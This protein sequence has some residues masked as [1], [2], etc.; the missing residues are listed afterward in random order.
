MV[1]LHINKKLRAKGGDFQLDIGLN[2]PQGSLTTIYGQS[3]A[4]KTSILRSIAGLLKPDQG[5]IIFNGEVWYSSEQRINLAPQ[6]RNVGYVFQDYA[7]FPNMT[8]LE[9][10]RF[11]QRNPGSGKTV[12]EL[13]QAMDLSGMEQRYPETLSGGQKQ[14]VALARALL[15]KPNILLLDEPLAALDTQMRLKLQDHI[16]QAHREFGLTTLLV[17]HDLGEIL[18]LSDTVVILEMGHIVKKGAPAEIFMERRLSGKFQFSGTVLDLNKQ[19][20]IYVV[21]VLIHNTLIKVVAH[22]SEIEGISPG[23][24]VIVASKAF[25]PLIYKIPVD[26]NK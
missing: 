7:L 1:E 5:E 6:K 4:G 20:V 24:E 25:N 12:S 9:N 14:R 17:S 23:D 21:S 13:I 10:L 8:V 2:V 26:N 16:L 18:K 15:Q 3:G 22:P 19:D 11:G